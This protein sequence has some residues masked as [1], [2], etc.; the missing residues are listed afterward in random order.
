MNE[1][2]RAL[3]ADT[4]GGDRNAFGAL[5]DLLSVRIFHYTRTIVQ[6]KEAAEDIT[7]DAFMRIHK[8]AL[9]IASTPNPLGYIMVMVRHCAFDSLKRNKL[10]AISLEDVVEVD[11]AAPIHTSLLMEDAFSRLPANQRESIYLRH[12]CGFTQKEVAQ[13]MHVPLATVKWRCGKAMAQLQD[14]F[15]QN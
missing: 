10:T 8:N 9:R 2:I 15:Q 11:A 1:D 14:Y 4:A 6:S 7:H 12:I 3:L 13:I 5:Y